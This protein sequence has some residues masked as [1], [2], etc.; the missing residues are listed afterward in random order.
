MQYDD[1]CRHIRAVA[2]ILGTEIYNEMHQLSDVKD[3]LWPIVDIEL[4]DFDMI[5]DVIYDADADPG[6][7]LWEG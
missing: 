6:D 4:V 5:Y 7:W 3:P 2:I 1:A